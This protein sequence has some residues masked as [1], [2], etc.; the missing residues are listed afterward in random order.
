MNRGAT[1]LIVA[2]GSGQRL[3]AGRPKA[4]V[5]LCGRPLFEWSLEACQEADSIGSVVIAAPPERLPELRREGVEVVAGGESRS[6]S[7]ARA[8]EEVTTSLVMVHDAARPLV[9]PEL[10]DRAVAAL[11]ESPELD[12]V[13]A[14]APAT[15]TIKRVDSGGRVLE[16]L[17]RSRLRMVQTPQVFRSAALR[18]AIRSG[19]PAA[20]TDDAALIESAGGSV[21]VIESPSGNIK[22]TVP[23]D[24]EYAAFRLKPAGAASAPTRP[25]PDSP[26][27]N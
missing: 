11:A 21:G 26:F 22:V 16:T 5:E 23:A 2:A 13:I 25:D 18:E 3:G 19:D 10:I 20:A 4:L 24:L 17:D 14:A 7:V 12:A 6:E 27:R 9:T 15:D 8:L 1:A